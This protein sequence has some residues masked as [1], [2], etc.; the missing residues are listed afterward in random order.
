MTR[1][2]TA[3]LLAAALAATAA[4]GGAFSAD[5]GV[6]YVDVPGA[7]FA[8]VIANDASGGQSTVADFSLRSLPVT[9][10]EFYRFVEVHPEWT[11]EAVPEVFADEGYLSD[12]R[13]S[14][15]LSAFEAGQPVTHVSWFAAQ[16]FCESEGARLPTWNEWER[17][18]SA[19]ATR[20]DARGDPAWRAAILNWYARPSNAALPAVGG[21]PDVHGVMNLHGLVWEWVD[22]FNA[23]LV[24]ADSRGNDPD[25]LKFC[26]AGAISLQQRENYAILMRVALLSSLKASDSTGSLGFRCARAH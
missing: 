14:A 8:S 23:L 6:P 4:T 2:R 22:D 15:S 7:R 5:T 21:P 13:P 10:G 9:R 16:A 24:D 17:A 25:K 3:L 19:D 26:G 1:R 20:E 18:A 12:A 11:R